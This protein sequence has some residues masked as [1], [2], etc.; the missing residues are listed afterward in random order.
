MQI[1]SK[2]CLLC[3]IILIVLLTWCPATAANL[4]AEDYYNQGI[5]YAGLRQYTEAIASYDNATR[6]DPE[7]ATAW[8]NRGSALLNLARYEDAVASYDNATR[9][10]PGYAN[11][12]INRGVALGRLARYEDAIASYDKGLKISPDDADAWYNRGNALLYLERYEDAIA[13]YDKALKINPGYSN[14]QQNRVVAQN[15]AGQSLPSP[16]ITQRQQPTP[17][18]TL[19][20]LNQEPT[21]KVPL[22]YAP[23]GAIALVAALSLWRRKS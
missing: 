11:A 19:P 3:G 12:W 18:M 9:I 17:T 23:F 13:S 6:I 14:A 15:Q 5:D 10:D 21:L 16:T 7:Y 22:L 2:L 20:P 1:E 4:T 8:Y